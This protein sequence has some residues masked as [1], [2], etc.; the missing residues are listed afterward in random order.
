MGEWRPAAD[1]AYDRLERYDSP[2]RR[3]R[4]D[5]LTSVSNI[6]GILLML[7]AVGAFALMDALMKLLADSYAPMQVSFLRGVTSL[8]FL[9]LPIFLRGRLAR[10]KPVN[11]PLHLFRG[12]LA[13]VMLGSFIYAVR[14]SS[15]T[16]T[17]SVF[18]FAPLL[19]AAIAGP[20]LGE[21]VTRVQWVAL[22]FGLLGVI[23][24]LRPDPGEWVSL[25]AL[26]AFIAAV[27]YAFAAATL[28]L[29]AR[30]DTTE[31]TAVSFV[32]LLSIG[33]G[34]LAAADWRAIQAEHWPLLLGLGLTGAFGQYLI[35]EAFRQAPASVIAP[36][37]YTALLWGVALDFAI[38]G[39]LPQFTT[40][41][42]GLVIVAAGLYLIARERRGRRP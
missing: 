9:L 17:Y 6:R 24:M 36:F 2:H 39:L 30:S 20:M 42:G 21:R 11:I 5:L 18:M 3:T 15:L 12:V 23:I 41:M 28:R 37:E 26:A 4:R 8:P 29:L 31:S 22:A 35:T 27:C 16:V 13:V 25:G 19:V 7:M 38:W 14:E 34:V 1:A 32:L 33:S 10:L 40:V